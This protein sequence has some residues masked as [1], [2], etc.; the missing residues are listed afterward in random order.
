MPISNLKEEISKLEWEIPY[1]ESY[2]QETRLPETLALIASK[3][4]RLAECE[5][6]AREFRKSLQLSPVFGGGLPD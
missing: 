6:L 5:K 4:S 3:K 1:L 2:Y